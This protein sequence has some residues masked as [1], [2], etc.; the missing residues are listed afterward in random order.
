MVEE[1]SNKLDDKELNEEKISEEAPPESEDL[2]VDE[3]EDTDSEI[4]VAEGSLAVDY[5]KL[6]RE[7]LVKELSVI[8]EGNPINDIRKDVEAIKASF[9][10]KQKL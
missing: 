1:P 7:D 5:T 4:V 8:I 3:S 10:K 2:S 6:S 9:Y